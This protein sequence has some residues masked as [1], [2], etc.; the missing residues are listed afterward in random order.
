MLRGGGGCVREPWKEE[1]TELEERDQPRGGGGGGGG[2]S[3]YLLGKL[4]AP[5]QLL[6]E[7]GKLL[8]ILLR[9]EVLPVPE[10]AARVRGGGGG[11]VNQEA[12]FPAAL[13]FA[14]PTERKQRAQRDTARSPLPFPACCPT[15]DAQ[16]GSG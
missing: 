3:P 8:L 5:Q 12:V 10:G 9:C 7:E 4:R 2:G 15:S 14:P 1:L 16:S 11:G 6:P 13:S